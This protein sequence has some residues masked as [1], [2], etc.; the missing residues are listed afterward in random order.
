M[1]TLYIVLG[2]IVVVVFTS[3]LTVSQ[4]SIAVITLFGKYQRILSPGLRMK[5][6]I[7][8]KVYR[9]IS[10]QNQSIEMEFQAITIDQANV[11]FKSMLLYSVMD[12]QEETIK[13]VAFKFIGNRDF[14]QALIRTI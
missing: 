2:I 12:E 4:G 7:F 3:F 8:E 6:P 9:Q 14:M 1:E 11:Y 5:I 13:K 10:V